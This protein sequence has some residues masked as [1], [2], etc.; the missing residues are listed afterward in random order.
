MANKK[1]KIHSSG[2]REYDARWLYPDQIDGAGMR[3][4]GQALGAYLTECGCDH[5]I[6]TGHD[7]RAYSEE[8]KENLIAG[9]VAAGLRVLDIGLCLS[10][11]LYFAQSVLKTSALAMVTASHNE[12]GWTGVKM[13]CASPLTFGPDEITALKAIA[14]KGEVQRGTGGSYEKIDGMAER[15]LADLADRPKFARGLR[16]VLACGNGTAGMFAPPLFERL[17]AEIIPLHCDLDWHFPRY[18]P[19]PENMSMLNELAAA[20]RANNADLGLAFDGDGDRCGFVDDR[21]EIIFA[22]KIGVLLARHLAAQHQQAR[23]IADVKSTGIFASDS[24]LI[25]LDARTEFWRTGHSY[26]KRRLYESGALAAF[27]KSGHFFFAP[28]IGRGYDDGLLSG[29]VLA[30]LIAQSGKPLSALY[31]TLPPSWLSPSMAP[32]CADEKKYQAVEKIAAHYQK[33]DRIC[34]RR[35]KEHI[36]VNGIRI[37]LEDGSWLLARASSNKPSLVIV[38]ESTQSQADMKALFADMDRVIAAIDEIGE[39]DQKI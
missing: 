25:A 24:E 10:P 12:N 32:F 29:I 30:E 26:M 14:L 4:L 33:R 21:G 7:Y 2:F 31:Q 13:G 3:H 39:Y 16:I 38:I 37:V 28:P 18:T 15:Y 36:R 35:V 6:I 1:I 5:S 34:G 20:V 8:V 23:F 17:G 19:N 27:E 11:T 9:L 22:D